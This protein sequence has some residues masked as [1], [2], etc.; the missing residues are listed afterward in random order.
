MDHGLASNPWHVK[1]CDDMDQADRVSLDLSADQRVRLDRNLRLAGV[2]EQGQR[3]LLGATVVVAGAG[4]LGSAAILY[5][6]AAGVG[7]VRIVDDGR[8]EPS[9]LNRQVLHATADVDRLKI[10]SARRGVLALAPDCRVET[11]AERIDAASAPRLVV[12]ADV[13]LDCTD[14]FATRLAL[15]DA[16]WR[17]G[18]PL[19]SAAVLRMEGQLLAAIP[20][21][22]NP[23]YRCLVPEVPPSEVSPGAAQV[24]ILGAVAGLFGSL[25]A[26]EAVKVLLGLGDDYARRLL[27]YDGLAGTFRTVGRVPDPACPTCG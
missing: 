11:A 5:L 12:G 2:G 1:A 3:R 26:V 18:V 8:V 14:N 15:A 16:A 4:G 7:R 23:C 21:P 6:A 19:V 17:A 9:N 22:G 27:I 25:Q 20:A 10:D 24:G 13:V